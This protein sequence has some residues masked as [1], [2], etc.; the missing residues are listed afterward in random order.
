MF[1]YKLSY[2]SHAGTRANHYHHAVLYTA[3]EYHLSTGG[4]SRVL[5]LRKEQRNACKDQVN[6]LQTWRTREYIR[7]VWSLAGDCVLEWSKQQIWLTH[8]V[9][10]QVQ[11][12]HQFKK[13]FKGMVSHSG[14][15]TLS[16]SGGYGDENID[17]T[18]TSAGWIWG[19]SQQRVSLA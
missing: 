7:H 4:T 19:D 8:T 12:T 9:A 6:T 1:H 14:K 11:V 16:L 15:Y 2:I 10:I 13:R 3:N 5:H 18:F 17:T